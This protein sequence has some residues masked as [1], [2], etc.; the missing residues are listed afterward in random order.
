MQ[1]KPNSRN[2]KMNINTFLTIRYGNLDTLMSAKTKP[3]Q[4]QL[5]P[6]QTQLKPIQTQLKPKQSQ[7]VERAKMNAFAWIENLTIVLIMLLA[8]FTTLKGANFKRITYSPTG[9]PELDKYMQHRTGA[10]LHR[11]HWNRA[12]HYVIIGKM[13]ELAEKTLGVII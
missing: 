11:C 5:K 6:I 13:L 7:F 8:E 3:K 12:F 4:T 9:K 1:N 2:G 10:D